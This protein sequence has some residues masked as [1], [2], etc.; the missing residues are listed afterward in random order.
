MVK[1]LREQYGS[2]VFIDVI[3]TQP[4]RYFSYHEVG[5]PCESID[6]LRI[7]RIALPEH[8]SGF[9]DQ[10]RAFFS[11]AWG[12][13]K[14]ARAEQYDVVLATSS[15]LMTAAL[16]RCIAR[17]LRIPLYLDIRDIFVENLPEM[18]PFRIG[19]LFS[20]IFALL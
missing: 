2:K 11:Y 16:G 8:H 18:L 13:Y 15:R 9:V 19:K 7:R 10:A 17:K 14:F 4:N 6:G 20:S 3:T 1:A 5:Q 12:V